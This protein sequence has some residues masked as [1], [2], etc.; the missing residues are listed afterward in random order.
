MSGNGGV[1]SCRAPQADSLGPE[2][3]QRGSA[4]PYVCWTDLGGSPES[5]VRVTKITASGNWDLLN[6][7]AIDTVRLNLLSITKP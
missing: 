6:N 3:Q 4:L 5:P 7:E 1:G 2:P